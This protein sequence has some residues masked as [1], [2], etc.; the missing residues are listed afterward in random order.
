ML[1]VVNPQPL[2]TG[3]VD[4]VQRE[5]EALVSRGDAQDLQ[6][7][8]GQLACHLVARSQAETAFYT[9]VALAQ[10]VQTQCLCHR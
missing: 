1:T 4:E 10:L 8:V 9:P 7:S 3:P 6:L 5:V 2:Q